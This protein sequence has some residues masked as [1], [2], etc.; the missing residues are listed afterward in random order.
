MEAGQ[1]EES[2]LCGMAH[3]YT[4]NP[5][6]KTRWPISDLRFYLDKESSGLPIY[7]IDFYQVRIVPFYESQSIGWIV[8]TGTKE[9][10]P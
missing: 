4:T 3:G 1:E 7:S 6:G 2:G 8:R 5:H 10:I 9:G